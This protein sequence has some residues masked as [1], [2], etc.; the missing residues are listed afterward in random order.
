MSKTQ[1]VSEASGLIQAAQEALLHGHTYEA[2]KLFRRA[3]E[4]EPENADAWV[5]LADAVRSFRE[6]QQHLQRALELDPNN[7]EAQASLSLVEAK[8]ASGE[9]L[10]PRTNTQNRTVPEQVSETLT[11]VAPV[12]DSTDGA[13]APASEVTTLYCY[14]HPD[15]ETGL[16]CTQCGRPICHECV[17]TALVGQLCPECTRERRPV[18]YQVST[19]TL[20]LAGF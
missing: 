11:E 17:N 4:L 3:T 9:L 5:G 2:S 8:L 10:A 18:N 7:E 1:S 19:K 13:E 20:V 15:R 12:T 14:R 16:Q 6:K